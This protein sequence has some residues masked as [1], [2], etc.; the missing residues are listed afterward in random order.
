MFYVGILY[1]SFF[2]YEFIYYLVSLQQRNSWI[3]F[4]TISVKLEI[5]HKFY[6]WL[7]YY[8]SFSLFKEE[9]CN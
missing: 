2:V 8:A 5:V 3:D 9:I 4:V 6:P 1:V 7:M